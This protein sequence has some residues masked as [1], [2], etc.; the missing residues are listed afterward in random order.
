MAQML[1]FAASGRQRVA[2]PASLADRKSISQSRAR[3]VT[4][5]LP[6]TISN[7]VSKLAVDPALDDDAVV[8]QPVG[9]SEIPIVDFGPFLNGGQP[10]RHSVADKIAAALEAVGFFYLVGHGVPPEVRR[11]VFDRSADFF[12]LP[13]EE[14]RKLKTTDDWN[15]GWI[16]TDPG[17]TLT[18]DSRVFEQYRIQREFAPDDPDLLTGSVFCQPN[19][20]PDQVPGFAEGCVNYFNAMVNLSGQLLHAFALGLGLPEDRFDAYFTKPISQISLMYYPPLPDNVGNEVKN[21]IAHTDDGPITIL[22]QGDIPGLEV[23]LRDGRWIA[24]PPI[25]G[26]YTINV[27][28]MM[29]W[30]SNGRYRSTLHRVRNVSR[31]ERFSVPF[32]SNLDEDVVVAPLPEL[33]ARD[34]KAH[35]SPMH[36]GELLSRF[37]KTFKYEP[38]ADN[39]AS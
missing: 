11:T 29:M 20:W 10:E 12:H 32:F 5:G 31:V 36:V 19:R 30:W 3:G 21:T 22:A 4:V 24:A 34:G 8:A 28:N 6:I 2:H 37:Y 27:G 7:G 17:K 39:A 1:D 14:R 26:A 18:A 9:I 25:P 38:Y 13:L 33:V 16:Q 23:K 35:Y 15:R